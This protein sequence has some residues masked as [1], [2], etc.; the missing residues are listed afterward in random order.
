M[1]PQ[2]NTNT[3]YPGMG[4]E[5]VEFY[6]QNGKLNVLHNKKMIPFTEVPFAVIQILKETIDANI[7]VKLALH[8]MHPHSQIQRLEQFAKCRFGGLD[9]EADIMDNVLQDGEYWPCPLRG[10]CTAEGILCKLPNINGVRLTNSEIDLLKLISSELTNEVIAEKL[11]YKMGTFHQVK[12]NLYKK[13]NIQTKQ[14][15]AKIAQ[16]LNII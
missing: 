11:G 14:G 6:E 2:S 10:K 8:E 1:T 12:K 3:L 13:L 9:F 5:A 15:G 4:C 7:E 16:R